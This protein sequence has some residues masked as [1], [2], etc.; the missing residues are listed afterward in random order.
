MQHLQT[1][2][3]NTKAFRYFWTSTF[4]TRRDLKA[5]TELAFLVSSD[6]LFHS[7]I[8]E[9]KKRIIILT[10]S[11]STVCKLFALLKLYEELSLTE[12]GTRK[13]R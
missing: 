8:T 13:K 7:L 5:L 9:G 10:C 11:V 1:P 4:W 6:K 2:V 3:A 12:G